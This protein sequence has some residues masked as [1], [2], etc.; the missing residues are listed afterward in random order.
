MPRLGILLMLMTILPA[1][2]PPVPGSGRW[3]WAHVRAY[4]AF[5]RIDSGHRFNDG[6][7]A[8]PSSINLKR[9]SDPNEI[10][11]IAADPRYLPHGTKIYVPGYWEKLQGN[12]KTIPT[13]MITVNDTCG[14]IGKRIQD[15]MR[16]IAYYVEVR[17]RR[18]RTARQWG[19]NNDSGTKY[20]KVFIYD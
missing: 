16:G 2:E 13:R 3:V 12:S 5:D 7:T 17:F 4:S 11:G 20:M 10:Y 15:S 6:R 18:E 14:G 9:T 8:P 1:A 19:V